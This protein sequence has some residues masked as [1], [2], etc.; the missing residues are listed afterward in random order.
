P[1]APPAP[2][3]G[4]PLIGHLRVVPTEHPESQYTQ[5][6]KDYGS[7]ILHFSVL[8]RSIVVL[9]SVEA[10]RDLLDKRGANYADRPRFVLFE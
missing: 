5:W 2:P 9:N 3:P 1:P 8:G 10:A 7:D 6:G 4:E